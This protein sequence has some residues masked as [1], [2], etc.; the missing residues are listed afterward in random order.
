ML[1]QDVDDEGGEGDQDAGPGHEEGRRLTDSGV[2]GLDL[3][4]LHIDDVVLLQIIIRRTDD[5]GIVEVDG[6]DFLTALGIFADEFHFVTDTINGEVA[7]LS[8]SLKNVDFFIIYGDKAA[9]D[10]DREGTLCS[11][12]DPDHG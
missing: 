9:D 10:R 12:P 4:G 11:C 6:V 1:L 3:V 2:L 5:V 8:Q 7:C